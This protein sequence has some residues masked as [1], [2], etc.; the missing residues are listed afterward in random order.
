MYLHHANIPTQ[1]PKTNPLSTG[2][3]IWL[4][5]RHSDTHLGNT[6]IRYAVTDPH[7]QPLPAMDAYPADYVNH[8]LPLVLLSG[9]EAGSGDGPTSADSYPLLEKKG[10]KVFSDFPPLSGAVAED[11]RRVFLEE[12]GTQMPWKSSLLSSTGNS[13]SLHMRYRI[14][15]AG[16]VFLPVP[17]T[18]QTACLANAHH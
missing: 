18:I 1:S 9:L 3:L 5:C 11:L 10:P 2:I 16:R 12:D 7:T 17:W 15:S 13:S 4:C 8:N 6:T 14:K